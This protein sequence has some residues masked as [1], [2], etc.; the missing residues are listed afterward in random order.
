MTDVPADS[1]SGGYGVWYSEQPLGALTDDLSL[2]LRRIP[3][4]F[5]AVRYG[6]KKQLELLEF[7]SKDVCRFSEPGVFV[8]DV[9]YT[10]TL[11]KL[12]N[13]FVFCW[14]LLACKSLRA[15]TPYD[16]TKMIS[17][18]SDMQS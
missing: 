5:V 4:G 3:K 7:V 11:Y 14:L 1:L 13:C 8:R 16:Y 10:A 18:L 15:M 9:F 6:S 12:E 2:V 17:A